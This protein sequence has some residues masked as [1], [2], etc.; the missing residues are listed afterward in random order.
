[1][2]IVIK[3]IILS[4][5][6][7]KFMEK[8]NFNF[9]QLIL[10][11]GGPPG[12][13]GPQG[14]AGPA[15]PKGDPGNKWYVGITATESEIGTTLYQGDLFLS[16][17]N[18]PNGP[19]GQV[20][21]WNELSNI[22][23]DTGLNLTG[24]TGAQGNSGANLFGS[25]YEG[26]TPSLWNNS[27]VAN[28]GPT[29]NFYLLKGD[30]DYLGNE[31]FADPNA[32]VAGIT[33]QYSRE[34][35]WLGGLKGSSDRNNIN[36]WPLDSMPK[37]FVSPRKTFESYDLGEAKRSI[38]G[39]ITLGREDTNGLASSAFP[40]SWS[41]I[42]VDSLM[43][44]RITNWTDSVSAAG[45]IQNNPSISLESQNGINLI[46]GGY[47]PLPSISS[48]IGLSIGTEGTGASSEFKGI[49]YYLL[50]S[51]G[52]TGM[53]WNAGG[54]FLSTKSLSDAKIQLQTSENGI[55]RLHGGGATGQHGKPWHS[56][57]LVQSNGSNSSSLNSINANTRPYITVVDPASRPGQDMDWNGITRMATSLVKGYIDT[58]S[59]TYYGIGNGINIDTTGD[60]GYNT[61]LHVSNNAANT[62]AGIQIGPVNQI[63]S[64]WHLVNQNSLDVVGR[65]RMRDSATSS[66]QVMISESSDGTAIWADSLTVG[67]WIEDVDCSSRIVIGDTEKFGSTLNK[68]YGEYSRFD[69]AISTNNLSGSVAD[70]IFANYTSYVGATHNDFSISLDYNDTDQQGQ[71]TLNSF[72]DEINY[73]TPPDSRGWSGSIGMAMDAYHRI[74]IGDNTPGIN[75]NP[76]ALGFY[77]PVNSSDNVS[78]KIV[79]TSNNGAIGNLQDFGKVVPGSITLQTIKETPDVNITGFQYPRIILS[80]NADHTEYTNL[81]ILDPGGWEDQISLEFLHKNKTGPGNIRFLGIRNSVT[82]FESIGTLG[83]NN[84]GLGTKSNSGAYAA[85]LSDNSGATSNYGIK[86]KSHLGFSVSGYEMFTDKIK[87]YYRCNDDSNPGTSS[88]SGNDDASNIFRSLSWTLKQWGDSSIDWSVSGN[89]SRGIGEFRFNGSMT[90][91]SGSA[92][93]GLLEWPI[94]YDARRNALRGNDFDA[95]GAPTGFGF[96]PVSSTANTAGNIINWIGPDAEIRFVPIN[97]DRSDVEYAN[98]LGFVSFNIPMGIIFQQAASYIPRESSGLGAPVYGPGSCGYGFGGGGGS[99]SARTALNDSSLELLPTDGAKSWVKLQNFRIKLPN[100]AV[101]GI[102]MFD[103]PN[104][105]RKFSYTSGHDP[106]SNSPANS[107]GGGN[108]IVNTLKTNWFTATCTPIQTSGKSDGNANFSS[109]DYYMGQNANSWYRHSSGASADFGGY[110]R[111]TK[112]F[113]NTTNPTLTTGGSSYGANDFNES[114]FG[115]HPDLAADY[116]KHH[117]QQTFQWRITQE[118]A[119]LNTL[120]QDVSDTYLE[121]MYQTPTQSANNPTST[122]YSASGSGNYNSLYANLNG[123]IPS[124]QEDALFASSWGMPIIT[125][126]M[127]KQYTS[128]GGGGDLTLCQLIA[129]TRRTK[130]FYQSHG[131][132]I[133][134]S[135]MVNFTTQKS[136]PISSTGGSNI[137][138]D[139][140][141]PGTEG[142]GGS[143]EQTTGRD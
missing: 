66:G 22:F 92:N 26:T 93:P 49:D 75:Y 14:L 114:T 58:G 37:L 15:G 125:P 64:A 134:G 11:G 89:G 61:L 123:T 31:L 7:E 76:T 142:G 80:N 132:S 87:M 136:S 71:L 85:L 2:S 94:R 51:S 1:M 126:C 129:D 121:F 63:A 6:L 82:E 131:F 24:P 79:G 47:G 100:S 109:N 40:E 128:S 45:V 42:V 50:G 48:N 111:W 57:S 143:A 78:L 116:G 119:G 9:D 88:I 44:L 39:G 81:G 4:D 117:Q 139:P 3:E 56:P 46:S 34:I 107:V 112:P 73:C 10:A 54:F 28:L 23:D 140:I 120:P 122:S 53:S 55:T 84:T 16:E 8:V 77:G 86:G 36:V 25:F 99:S 102:S 41:N 83:A 106:L 105:S 98:G 138:I 69:I 137:L 60:P 104:P 133:N 59:V 5:T 108:R 124:E 91:S 90:V 103:E 67:A 13:I 101:K 21:E 97:V 141:G 12:P 62:A 135:A 72:I 115:F 118:R 19:T 74:V 127:M 32:L 17:A 70:L 95:N 29:S 96:N 30:T 20:W 18:S 65:I 110:I 52:S 43:N 35:L 33:A 130:A 68:D 38:G 27:L 113:S